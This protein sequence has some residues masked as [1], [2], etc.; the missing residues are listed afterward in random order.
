MNNLT[1]WD[2]ARTKCSWIQHPDG[3]PTGIGTVADLPDWWAEAGVNPRLKCNRYG[4]CAVA[5]ALAVKRG[6]VVV[7]VRTNAWKRCVLDYLIRLS[8]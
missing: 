6:K 4:G 2:A 1:S 7:D 3:D 8:H 5:A